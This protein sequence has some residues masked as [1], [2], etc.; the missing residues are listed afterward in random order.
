MCRSRRRLFAAL[1]GGLALLAAACATTP[2]SV[3]APT[4][5]PTPPPA[6]TPAP[7]AAPTTVPTP[8]TAPAVAAA[9]P[10]TAVVKPTG[11]SLTA[12]GGAFPL[13]I[14]TKFGPVAIPREPGRVLT[15]GFSE[16]DPVLAV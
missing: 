12:R 2:P 8:T 15:I 1:P 9:P 5:A 14:P 11:E 16:Q 3:V 13:T 4:P 6:P 7:T 10:A